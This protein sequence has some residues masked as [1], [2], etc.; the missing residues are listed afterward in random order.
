MTYHRMAGAHA[1]GATLAEGVHTGQ[2]HCHYCLAVNAPARQVPGL[3]QEAESLRPRHAAGGGRAAEQV[4]ELRFAR[5]DSDSMR[6]RQGLRGA[7]RPIRLA[8]KC[9]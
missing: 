9:R 5:V 4:P 7:A 3:L 1:K 8:E 2:L 6:S